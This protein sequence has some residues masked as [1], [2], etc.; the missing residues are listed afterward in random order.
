MKFVD[1][2]ISEDSTQCLLNNVE[3]DIKILRYLFANCSE[4]YS[5]SKWCA[6]DVPSDMVS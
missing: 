1:T 5:C 4:A 2:P 6:N 3:N